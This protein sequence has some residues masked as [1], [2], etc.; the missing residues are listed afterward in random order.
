MLDAG[1]RFVL[2]KKYPREAAWDLPVW[3][4]DE[5]IAMVTHNL[6][7]SSV[8]MTPPPRLWRTLAYE[9]GDPRYELSVTSTQPPCSFRIKMKRRRGQK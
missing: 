4:C 7:V 3:Y 9:A 8:R 5:F 1:P 6:E 2:R